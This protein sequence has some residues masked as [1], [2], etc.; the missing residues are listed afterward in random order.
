MDRNPIFIGVTRSFWSFVATLAL[1][2]DMGEPIV[3]GI[4][5]LAANVI[6]GDAGAY[7]EWA[8][9]VLPVATLLLAMQQRSGAARPYTLDPR[10]MR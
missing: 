1:M 8:M 9:T 6:G 10:A 2:Q 4:C 3:R 5:T 7:T